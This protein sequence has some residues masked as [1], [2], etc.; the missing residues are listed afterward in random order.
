MKLVQHAKYRPLLRVDCEMEPAA[1]ED[2]QLPEGHGNFILFHF[3]TRK[4]KKI[5]YL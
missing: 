2:H 3:Y 1:A 5:I 4:E